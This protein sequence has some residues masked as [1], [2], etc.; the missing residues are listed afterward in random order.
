MRRPQR[1]ATASRS[2]TSRTFQTTIPTSKKALYAGKENSHLVSHDFL[3][4]EQLLDAIRLAYCQPNVGGFFNFLLADEKSLA[5]WQSG[6]SG[7]T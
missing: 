4:R 6:A 7:P 1:G 3:H 2:G 5:G